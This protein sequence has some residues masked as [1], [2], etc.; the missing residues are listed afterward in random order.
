LFDSHPGVDAGEHSIE[1]QLPFLQRV[2]TDFR[3]VPLY[4]GRMSDGDYAAAARAILPLVD[5]KTLL[6]ASTDFTHFGP[7]FGYQPFKEDV[8]AKLRELADQ[9]AN[10]IVLCDFDGFGG[11]LRKTRDT[12]C[13]RCPVL[14]LLRVLSMQGGAK[15][16]RAAFDTSGNLTGDWTNSVSYL[17]FVFTRRPGTL[18]KK[19]RA[20]S[21]RL[22]RQTVTAA[23]NSKQPPQPNADELPEK[24]RE[25]GACFVTLEN[26]GRL[27]G[28]IGNMVAHGPL[29]EAVIHNAVSAC[30]DRR[31]VRNPVTADELKELH[32][33]ISY[34][35]PM[36]LVK[37]TDEII[38]GRHG[39]LIEL[40]RNRGV[41]L[42]QVAYER[43]WTRT[44]FLDQTCHKAGLPAEAW[45]HPEA[46]IY[47]FQAEV[48]G[49][50]ES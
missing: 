32:I 44:E 41:L 37:D 12:I 22:A 25:D 23:L 7:S 39:L 38:I 4:I 20:E 8:P 16:V 29:Y 21:L 35:T 28:C 10:P 43:G 17:S 27:R 45:K 48:F 49:E 11:H 50:S 1:L 18:G 3:I 15:G 47:C 42:P 34:L 46:K 31:F 2:L 19:E 14:L 5:D 13:G 33:E 6:V 36:V 9:A 26:H 30:R 40:G 24:L